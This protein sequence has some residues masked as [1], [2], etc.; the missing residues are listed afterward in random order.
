MFLFLQKFFLFSILLFSSIFI[1]TQVKAPKA[2]N[3]YL[4]PPEDI[5]YFTLGYND[6]LAG[7]LWIRAL[8]NF[9]FCEGGKYQDS[10]YSVP[11]TA[12]K[13][14]LKAVLQRKMKASKCHLG[15]VYSM[16]DAM[17]EIQPRFKIA[18]E[19]GATFLS[20]VVDDREGAR[21]IF[22]KGLKIYP[23]EWR[24]SYA[25]GY[26]YL[27]EIQDAERAG[28]LLLQ[29]LNSGGPQHLASLAAGLYTEAGQAEFARSV[30]VENLKKDLPEE[31]R[32]RM[33]LRLKDI[34]SILESQK[35]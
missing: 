7:V 27:W 19:T 3:H 22:E 18:Y 6:A 8:Q 34:E 31:V 11:N 17:T 24:L 25:A 13:N 20:V 9:D 1:Q 26:H 10:D 2:P 21:R 32:E 15:W 4:R 33:L 5:K 35:K 29:S 14:K 12:E 16:L 23:E 28:A 30:L